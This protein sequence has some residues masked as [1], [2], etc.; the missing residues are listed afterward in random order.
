MITKMKNIR[1]IIAFYSFFAPLVCIS[2]LHGADAFPD[3]SGHWEG[4][5]TL[6]ATALAIQVDLSRRAEVWQG[7]IDIPGQGLRG[8][9]LDSVKINGASVEFAMAGIPGNPCFVGRLTGDASAMAGEFTQ[10][11]GRFPF[12]LER[13]ALPAKS[14]EPP[15]A[16]I[17]GRGLQGHWLGVLKPMPGV[18]LRIALEIAS[19]EADKPEGFMV[20]LDQGNAVIPISAVTEQAG[21]V[22]LEM[23]RIGGVF[24]GKFNGDG[25]ELSGEWQQGGPAHS[26]V[27]K[28]SAREVGHALMKR[29]Q[30]P[31]Q[32]F[33]YAV[34]EVSVENKTAAVT[35]AGTLSLP[36]GT[37]PH[38]AVVLITGS[39]QQDRDET[40]AGHKPFL[41]LAD[42]LARQGIAV[43]RCDDRG[44]G[45]STGDFS[46][47]VQADFVADT[48]AA[49]RY[50]QSRREIAPERVGLIGHSEGGTV[51]LR[52]AVNSPE[53]AFIVLLAGVALPMEESALRQARAIWRLQGLSEEHI[54]M[55]VAMQQAVYR[56]SKSG[57]PQAAAEEAIRM[58]IR[59]Q[60][61]ALSEEQ[62]RAFGLNESQLVAGMK[63]VFSPWFR[64]LLGYDPR[65]TLRAV[66]CPV[67]AINGEKD[68]QVSAKDNLAAIRE[69]LTAGGNV[70][71]KTVELP[72][73]NHLFQ[74]CQT[75]SP[76]EYANLTETFNPV[77]L[78][79][80]SDWLRE[81]AS[82]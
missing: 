13:K 49:V 7:T 19:T 23:K 30:T 42:H 3:P 73:L 33:P 12:K 45:K 61:A 22:R 35:L 46:Q 38:P 31:Q 75:G 53:V 44:A 59:E 52:A 27:F 81:I 68:L 48:L 14:A 25:S 16:G 71:V 47:A 74:T 9:I 21:L 34:E 17:P 20:S 37:G 18:E 79:L 64:D 1:S 65:T 26:L 58:V 67:L 78:N 11:P 29:P 66:K 54:A 8:F 60:T 36:A 24:E 57:S 4:A 41:V 70:R 10:G 55:H 80:V 63:T 28:R 6:P 32:P 5:I 72:G 40:V 51:A 62:K 39:G 43:L 15:V 2:G 69:A 77:A 56:I 76:T 82:P 50:L